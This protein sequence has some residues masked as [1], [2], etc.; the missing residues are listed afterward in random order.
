MKMLAGYQLNYGNSQTVKEKLLVD[1]IVI[2][3]NPEDMLI[4]NGRLSVPNEGVQCG[5]PT[6]K[7]VSRLH[8]Q[9]GINGSLCPI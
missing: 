4:E 5:R 9:F 2:R 8:E 1:H 3:H 6:N 7:D